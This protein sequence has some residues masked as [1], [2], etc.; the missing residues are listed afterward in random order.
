MSDR[1]SQFMNE[2]NA[3]PAFLAKF[4]ANKT[5]AMA[6]FNLTDQEQQLVLNGDMETLSQL[7][8]GN[9]PAAKPIFTY[10]SQ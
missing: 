10:H 6:S 2:V 7:T 3:N 1:L 9:M 8:T 4:K 5:Q